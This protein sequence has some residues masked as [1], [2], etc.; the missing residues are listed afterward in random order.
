MLQFDVIS[1]D[2]ILGEFD[3]LDLPDLG[4]LDPFYDWQV[5]YVLNDFDTD[6]VRV[7]MVSTGNT[8]VPEP[9]TLLLMLSGLAG[10]GFS[11]RGKRA[12]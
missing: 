7:S 5:S 10:I 9:S 11:R 2:T 3:G 1:A 6:Y 12:A 4:A 8:A